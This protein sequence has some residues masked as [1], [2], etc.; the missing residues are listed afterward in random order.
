MKNNNIIKK[1]GRPRVEKKPKF[2]PPVHKSFRQ[3]VLDKVIW[4]EKNNIPIDHAYKDYLIGKK[5]L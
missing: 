1:K 3:F 2:I 5:I 4:A